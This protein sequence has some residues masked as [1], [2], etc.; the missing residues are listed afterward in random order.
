LRLASDANRGGKT[1][2]PMRAT[3]DTLSAAAVLNG[4]DDWVSALAVS[5]DGRRL[6]SG[7]F[8]SRVIV[9]DAASHKEV[10]RWSGRPWNWIVAAA[11]SPDGETA[12]V[13]E[14]RYKRDDFDVPAAALRVWNVADAA[15]KLDLLKIEFPKFNPT[16]STY[17]AAQVWRKFTG[18][19]LVAAD[20]SP[21]G[22]LLALG[23]GGE[24]D[25]GKVHLFDA[26][27][28][29]LLRTVSGHRYG[30]TDVRFSGDGRFVL[31]VG[32]DTMLRICDAS[33]G[34]EAAALGASRGGQFK[35][36]LSALAV[37][38]DGRTLAAADIAG[39]VHVWTV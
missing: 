38:P 22:K 35:D 10:I 18:D 28:G 25:T 13:S 36:W 26:A 29:K 16:A 30:V 2:P 4:H 24:T 1:P 19:G 15:E 37:S 9:W 5:R 17:E 27:T 7:D 11:L 12:L 23:Q 21:D 20:A 32:R 39:L 34:K 6:V 33:S 31:S 14:F 8:G 3:V